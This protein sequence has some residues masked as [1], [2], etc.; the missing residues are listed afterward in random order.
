[1]QGVYLPQSLN[2]AA[3]MTKPVYIDLPPHRKSCTSRFG[4]IYTSRDGHSTHQQLHSSDGLLNLW[5]R[6]ALSGSY[7]QWAKCSQKNPHFWGQVFLMEA[8]EGLEPYFRWIAI[9][10]RMKKQV[11]VLSPTVTRNQSQ[12]TVTGATSAR[13]FP[14][15]GNLDGFPMW[16]FF[17]RAQMLAGTARWVP[18]PYR[19]WSP[20]PCR[21]T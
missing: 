9:K 10:T 21:E 5:E 1:M 2:P 16:I 20:N 3:R 13:Y 8:R 7:V 15:G 4:S 6:R 17:Q 18:S 12:N 11:N 19:R 14:K